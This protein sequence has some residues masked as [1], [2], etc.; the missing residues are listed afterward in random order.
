MLPANRDDRM[1]HVHRS[2]DV[3]EED[4]VAAISEFALSNGLEIDRTH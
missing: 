1:V 4:F 2:L 3:D